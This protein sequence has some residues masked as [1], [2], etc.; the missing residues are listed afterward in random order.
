MCK[1]LKEEAEAEAKE[2][3]EVDGEAGEEPTKEEKAHFIKSDVR[4][5]SRKT[6]ARDAF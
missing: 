3:A 1:S 6:R 2:E 5:S 4:R